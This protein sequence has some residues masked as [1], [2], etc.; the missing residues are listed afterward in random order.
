MVKPL[1]TKGDTL[2]NFQ[3]K[4]NLHSHRACSTSQTK[5]YG[6]RTGQAI[7]FIDVYGQSLLGQSAS[8][9]SITETTFT[10]NSAITYVAEGYVVID[11]QRIISNCIL[12]NNVI[13]LQDVHGEITAEQLREL[14]KERICFP[15]NLTASP[16]I[17]PLIPL[18]TNQYLSEIL[19]QSEIGK[20]YQICETDETGL[21]RILA[22]VTLTSL[23]S[24]VSLLGSDGFIPE[25]HG[26]GI[27][28]L[29]GGILALQLIFL[30][31]VSEIDEAYYY[32]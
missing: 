5:Y 4:Y 31:N 25:G 8:I 11:S 15:L 12:N 3:T 6:L 23:T 13:T 24:Q 16:D 19:I 17:V 32:L 2:D 10:V 26:V 9:A 7:Q 20:T 14:A 29:T 27:K 28:A 22:S 1:I 30:K 21:V 18:G